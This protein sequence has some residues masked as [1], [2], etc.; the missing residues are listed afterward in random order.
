MNVS[1]LRLH[2]EKDSRDLPTDRPESTR[3]NDVVVQDLV[4]SY[5]NLNVVDGVSFTVPK[6]SVF[7]LIGPNGAGKSTT[8]RMMMRLTGISS[9]KAT[10]LGADVETDFQ[11]VKNRIGYVPEVHNV[12]RWMSIKR[13]ISFVSSFY[14]T[15]NQQRCEEMLKLLELQPSKKVKQLSKG[16]LAKLALLLAVSHEPELLILDE[17]LSGLDPLVREEFLEGVMQVICKG[18]SSVIFSSHTIGDVQRIADNVGILYGGKLLAQTGVDDLVQSVKRF[19]VVVPDGGT[20]EWLPEDAVFTQ[21]RGREYCVTVKA[22]SAELQSQFEY[23]NPGASLTSVDDL[24]LEEIFKDF[25]RGAK[26]K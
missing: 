24:N 8:L 6:G 17:P 22:Y 23:R 25:V 13:I 20:L 11:S 3:E 14:P 12:Y 26:G 9:G 19:K 7:G 1:T 4:K 18:S 15:W 2:D 21:H 16:M 10:V 5:G